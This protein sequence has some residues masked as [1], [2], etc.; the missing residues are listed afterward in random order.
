M[1]SSLLYVL[2]KIALFWAH[3]PQLGTYSTS[4]F[5][6]APLSYV[7]KF[8]RCNTV[9]NSKK[10][11]GNNLNVHHCDW[12]HL[13]YDYKLWCGLKVFCHPYKRSISC[14]SS[15]PPQP[16]PYLPSSSSPAD[17]MSWA[18]AV[19]SLDR[20]CAGWAG[21]SAGQKLIHPQLCIAPLLL[22]SPI[23]WNMQVNNFWV[24]NRIWL[25]RFSGQGDSTELARRSFS[26]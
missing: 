26:H 11:T 4:T 15:W 5:A 16:W 1:C 25:R 9:F 7:S 21:S 23:L 14:R 10:R 18:A 6:K 8:V 19:Q 17:R 24:L 2:L 20:T 22:G 13:N 3:N 12:N